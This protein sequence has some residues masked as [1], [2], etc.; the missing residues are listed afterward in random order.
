MAITIIMLD[1]INSKE[2]NGRTTFAHLNPNT[3]TLD[4][5]GLGVDEGPASEAGGMA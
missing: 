1:Q 2:L 3:G 4:A 5:W